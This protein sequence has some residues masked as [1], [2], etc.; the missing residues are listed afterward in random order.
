[1]FT[2]IIENTAIL[3]ELKKNES[4]VSFYFESS[5]SSEL[6]VD[7]SLSHNGVCLTVEEIQGNQYRVTA[8]EETLKKTNLSSLKPGDTVN[9]ERSMKSDARFDGHMVQGHVDQVGECVS[10]E[11]QNGSWKIN[12]KYDG[13]TGNMT[14]EKGSIC[15]NGISLTVFDSEKDSFAVAII[16]YTWTHTN[17]QHIKPGDKINLEFDIVGKYLA[18]MFAPFAEKLKS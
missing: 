15:L 1:M 6:K 18:K 14:V 10:V 4:N 5:I 3:K 2:G 9:L 16:P 12:V 17:L 8:I 11:D 7:Q 13:S